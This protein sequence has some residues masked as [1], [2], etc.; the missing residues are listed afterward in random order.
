[1]GVRAMRLEVVKVEIS[2]G[3]NVIIGQAHF[4]KTVEDVYEVVA[5]TCPGSKFGIAFAEASGE[6][7]IRHDGNDEGLESCAIEACKEI[8]AGHSFIIYLKGG[9][10]ISLLNALKDVQEVCNI[11]CATANQLEAVVVESETGRGILGVID[12]CSPKGVEGEADKAKRAAFLRK[13]GYKR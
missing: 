13:I 7:L 9:Y 12:G 11:F 4:V 3:A 6:C 1:M 2:D 5:T 8:G 10:P